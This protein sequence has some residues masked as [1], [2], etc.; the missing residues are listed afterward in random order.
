MYKIKK[1]FEVAASHKLSLSYDS[2]CENLHG[3]N[4]IITVYCQ[5]DKL[6]ADGMVIDFKVIKD[7]IHGAMDHSYLNDIFP[8]PTAENMVVYI[9]TIIGTQL[10]DDLKLTKVVLWETEG[11]YAEWRG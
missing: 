1:K 5:N 2:P 8:N 11:S 9:A 4:W 7:I 10:T 3:H 6:D